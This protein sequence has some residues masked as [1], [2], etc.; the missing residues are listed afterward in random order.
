M[1]GRAAALPPT[2]SRQTGGRAF[3][4]CFALFLMACGGAQ[5]R[6]AESI[7][8]VLVAP[9]LTF[10]DTPP[11]RV[12]VAEEDAASREQLQAR[13]AANAALET[14]REKYRDLDFAGSL[15]AVGEAQL[16]IEPKVQ[17]REDVELLHRALLFRAMNELA[18][19]NADRATEA[20]RATI[21]LRPDAVLDEGLFPP[22]VRELHASTLAGL[23]AEPP[24]AVA[25]RTTP[26]AALVSIDGVPL[27]PSP[28]SLN[29]LPGRH[30]VRVEALGHEPR[31]LPVILPATTS[32]PIEVVLP[33]AEGR[34]LEAQL[35][36]AESLDGID[37]TT[38]RR[39]AETLRADE[40]VRMDHGHYGYR[41][42]ALDL[43]TGARHSAE[44]AR[45]E[46]DTEAARELLSILH[47]GVGPPDDGELIEEPAFWIAIGIA[48]AAGA[49]A[50]ILLAQDPDPVVVVTPN[51]ARQN[52]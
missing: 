20:M 26:P 2:P 27:G 51:A 52:P 22:D 8:S 39:I 28:V 46:D 7:E 14:A 24:E 25:V 42:E 38:R 48:A 33:R 13:E 4:L 23:R 29:A 21:A 6:E 3:A 31:V 40:L 47:R 34:A 50:I 11:A 10:D 17:T 44:V 41:A 37:V 15:A 30:F 18:L 45:A 16:A 5:P 49:T 32:D 35:A 12:L 1:S 9:S 43:G 19:G 36:R